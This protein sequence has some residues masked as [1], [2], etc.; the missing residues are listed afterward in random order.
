[1]QMTGLIPLLAHGWH[2][3]GWWAGGM[4]AWMA[5]FWGAVVLGIAWLFRRGPGHLPSS[6]EEALRILDRRFAEGAITRDEYR[7]RKSVLTGG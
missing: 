7:E 2:G 4:M 5:I 6:E 3:D 1:M